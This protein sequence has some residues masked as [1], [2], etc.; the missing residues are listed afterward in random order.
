VFDIFILF[1]LEVVDLL[2]RIQIAFKK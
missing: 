1:V 2:H